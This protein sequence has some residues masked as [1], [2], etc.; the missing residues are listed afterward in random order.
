MRSWKKDFKSF[1]FKAEK[2]N[3]TDKDNQLDF[4]NFRFSMTP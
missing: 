2:K 3:S 4:D 1:I